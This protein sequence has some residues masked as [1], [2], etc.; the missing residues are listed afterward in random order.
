MAWTGMATLNSP[1]WKFS[2]RSIF[3]YGSA[4]YPMK[5]FRLITVFAP[6]LMVAGGILELSAQVDFVTVEENGIHGGGYQSDVAI[7][8]D[9]DTVISAGDVSGIHMSRDGGLIFHT[10][11]KG[12]RSLKVA[13]VA[14]TPDNPNILYAGTGDKG[15]S[16]GLFISLDGGESWARTGAGDEVQFS[17]NHSRVNDPL[18]D[19]HPR[20]NG[21]LVMVVPGENAASHLDDIVIC[22][23][24]NDGVKI[25][26]GGGDQVAGTVGFGG[27]DGDDGEREFVR[28]VAVNPNVS[29]I[30]YAAIYSSQAS[31]NGIYRIDFATPN[32]PEFELVYQTP[33]PEE[34]VLLKNG[35]VYAAVGENGLVGDRGLGWS[36][37]SGG[38]AAGNTFEWAAIAGYEGENGDILY[39]T[40]NNSTGG[41]GSNYSSVWRSED[42]GESWEALVDRNENVSVSIFDG[43]PQG[44][45]T[46][47]FE[48]GF[49]NALLGRRQTSFSS[50]EVAHGDLSDPADDVI[51][52]SGRGGIWKSPDGG[53]QWWPAVNNMQVTANRAVA[54]DPD[55][56]AQVVIGNTDF[57]ILHSAANLSTNSVARDK[58]N[59]ADS[60]AYA[61][62]VDPVSD[63]A[64]AATGNRN[65]NINGKVFTKPTSDLGHPADQ[66]WTDLML[67][68]TT[69]GGIPQAVVAGYHD[70]ASASSQVI[71]T[72][73]R[74]E[75]VLRYHDGEWRPATGVAI[76]NS[77]RSQLVWPDSQNSGVVFLI[78]TTAGLYRSTDGGQTWTNIWSGMNFRNNDFYL[79]GYIAADSPDTLYLSAQ[80]ESGSFIGT[81][82]R[83]YRLNQADTANFV[84]PDIDPNIEL[85]NTHSG[86]TE[87]R[88]PGPVAFDP[89]G[90]LWLAQQADSSNNDLAGLYLM[91]NPETDESFVD[92]TSE[93]Y[94]Q[95]AINPIGMAVSADGY[96]YIAQAGL[97]VVKLKIY[98]TSS[99]SPQE[100]WREHHFENPENTGLGADF[101]DPDKDGLVNF[102]EYATRGNPNAPDRLEPL[103]RSE[104]SLSGVGTQVRFK[105]ALDPSLTY[106]LEWSSTLE[107]DDWEVIESFPGS[108]N[109]TI[110]SSQ[111]D[112]P[113]EAAAPYFLR[114]RVEN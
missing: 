26:T 7:T 19:G 36:E 87:F 88:R 92:K 23:T 9:G 12:L 81:S 105:R 85:I 51:Y 64:I 39:A 95:I 4:P 13:T 86:G 16:G 114:L 63:V 75:G 31:E 5:V 54:V 24:Y 18:P 84:D 113:S 41:G 93:A 76:G 100:V 66:G 40:V 2:R 107:A 6:L 74:G 45:E 83:V 28:S 97:G 104:P 30:A 37:L 33:E 21:N 53:G 70:G 102:M 96:I 44:G 43:T 90:R 38:L 62:F 27:D 22:G 98:E 103:T 25:L 106:T 73:V 55:N 68:E 61:V 15:G 46:W 71:L 52:V 89:S 78:D 91:E 79:A 42:S 20:S 101:A 57:V 3:A 10:K 108:A 112:W 56:P 111:P 14:I 59:G 32:A 80:G 8:P 60:R 35:H 99:P 47:W 49:G 34:V 110:I 29:N 77:V 1:L 82:F 72:V 109:D 48:K 11:N 67:Q 69:A 94:E 17:G 50:I 65:T 58:P